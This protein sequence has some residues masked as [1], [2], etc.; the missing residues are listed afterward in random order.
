MSVY[1]LVWLVTFF[2]LGAGMLTMI[3]MLRIFRDLRDELMVT[4]HI[5]RML[6]EWNQKSLQERLDPE[7]WPEY[8]QER[9]KD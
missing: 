4:R 8:R 7:F 5:N 6:E 9:K 3:G 2:Y 1:S